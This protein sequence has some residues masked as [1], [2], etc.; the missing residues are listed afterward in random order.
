MD[1]TWTDAE[2]AFRAEARAWLVDHLA[3][4]HDHFDG[5]IH[6]G[7]TREG[8]AQHLVWERMLFDDRW[9]VVSWPEAYGGRDASLWEWLIFEEEY[10]RAGGP[11]RVTQNGIF[12]LAPSIFE[13]GTPAQQDGILRR[14]AAGEDLWCQGW[15]EPNAGSDLAS[16][17]SRATKVDGGWQLNGQK[18]WTTRG[19]FCTHLFGLFRSDPESERHKGLTY[20]LVPLDLDGI[21]VRGFSR[22]DGDEGFA[23]VFFEDAF[24]PDDV[25]YG[26]PVLGGIDG[27]WGVAMATTSSERGLT[28]RSPGRFMATADRLL[29][30]W[31]ERGGPAHLRDRVIQAW[32]KAEA[33]RVQTLQ[34]V[35]NTIEGRPA[36]AETSLV[37]LWWS[38]LDVELHELALDLLGQDAELE[39]PWSKGWM[40]S[41]SGPIYAG[42]NEVQ[43][44]IAAERVLGLPRR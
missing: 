6:S 17:R 41:L 39:G 19:A 5:T 7:D 32:M 18:T 29:Q 31:K 23:E 4:W 9:A 42:T 15:S 38:E 22:L 21:T 12:L 44:N 26:S 40:F 2:E 16:L 25:A 43:R 30:L 11:Q 27:G 10:Y 28:L 8:F 14:M 33:Y 13:F 37:K 20:L 24:L 34:T 36:G 3:Q 1:L 35:T